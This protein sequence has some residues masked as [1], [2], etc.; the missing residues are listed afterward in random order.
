MLVFSQIALD[1]NHAIIYNIIQLITI[2]II[3]IK[4]N[5]IQLI[6]KSCMSYVMFETTVYNA[7]WKKSVF[8]FPLKSPHP[9]VIIKW[10]QFS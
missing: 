9:N 8:G 7:L 6:T 2:I 3:Y 4:Y 5:I 10:S 1:W